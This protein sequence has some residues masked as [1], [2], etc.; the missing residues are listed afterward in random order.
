MELR[1]EVLEAA[2]SRLCD[3]LEDAG[4]SAH[5][6][7][8]RRRYVRWSVL[9]HYQVCPTPLLDLTHSLRVASSFAEVTGSSAKKEPLV[10]VLGLPFITNR[11]SLNTEHDLVNVRLLSICPPQA[12]RPYFQDGYLAGTDEITTNYES[13]VELDFN[14]R[15]IA[16]FALGHSEDFWGRNFGPIPDE[17]LFPPGD[18]V[19]E[20]WQDIRE[21]VGTEVAP[22]RIGRFLSEWTKLESALMTTARLHKPKVYSVREAIQVLRERAELTEPVMGLLH[23]LRQI[24]NQVVHEPDKV[25]VQQV[26]WAQEEIERLRSE[27]NHLLE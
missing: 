16:K 12:L 24:R 18:T 11:I 14:N 1:F 27:T 25:D 13:K 15:L 23:E 10:F 2:G 5:R 4:L 9:Q 3:A 19:E 7:L 17:I 21:E 8:R 22:G 6:G 20:I 26:F